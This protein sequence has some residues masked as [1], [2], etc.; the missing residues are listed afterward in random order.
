MS[1]SPATAGSGDKTWTC[2]FCPL[3]CDSF[4]VRAGGDG[5]LAL[6]GSQC[7]RA[8]AALAAQH[9]APSTP[10]ALLDGQPCERAKAM[11]TARRWLRESQQPLFGGLGADVAGARALYALAAATGA[12]SDAAAG[13]AFAQGLRVLQDRGQFTTTLAEVRGRADVVVCLGGSPAERQPEFFQRCGF[14]EDLVPARHVVFIGGTAADVA[15][16]QGLSGVTAELLP[17]QGD[18]FDTVSLLAAA[19]AGHPA[20]PPALAA[21]A[22]R[23]HSARYAVLAWEAWRL[24]A[25]GALLV[26]AI[27]RTVGTLN[28]KTR[29][30]ALPLGGGDGAATS[31]QV[32]AWL[33]GL[34]LRTRV[35]A[36]GLEHEPHAFD[37]QRLLDDG[38]V[39]LLL[40]VNAFGVAPPPRARG[41]RLLLLGPPSV[42][43]H[44][45]A[46]GTLFIP[47]ATPGIGAAGHL[48]RTDGVVMLPLHAVRDDG[49]PGVAEVAQQLR[50]GLAA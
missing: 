49:L 24:P 4:G 3:L 34:P 7:P 36:R 35:G 42:A 45:G 28:R 11:D 23:L 37:T 50:E 13:A 43:A 29:A 46:P 44:A 40:W 12:I 19:V 14:G 21:L 18:L 27:N 6:S 32:F 9:I 10:A 48:F 22:Q 8:A 30:A 25:Q 1:A 2:P 41:Q 5:S 17:L 31:N 15:A 47:V 20:V 38:A 33:S 16:L 39:D 26:E